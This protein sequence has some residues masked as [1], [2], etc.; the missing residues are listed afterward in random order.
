MITIIYWILIVGL[1]L[2]VVYVGGVQLKHWPGTLIVAGVLFVAGFLLYF[3]YLEQAFVKRWGGVMSI[4]LPQGQ[5]HLAATWKDD[6]LWVE[7]YDP[8]TNTCIF[9]EYSRG[10]MLEGKVIIKDCNPLRR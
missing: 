9:Q 7:N 10:H 2:G 6:N 5:Q 8:A 3:L 1:I 4:S